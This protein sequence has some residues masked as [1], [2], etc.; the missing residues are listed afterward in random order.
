MDLL[1]LLRF[2]H[3]V[4]GAAWWGTVFFIVFILTSSLE[5]VDVKQRNKLAAVIYPRIYN[6]TTVVSSATIV[7]GGASALLLSGG[8]LEVFFTPRGA[9]LASGSITGLIVYVA[10]LTVERRERSVL[11]VLAEF[12]DPEKQGSFL[13]DMRLI[14][15]IGFILLTYTMLSMIYFTIGA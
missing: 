2:L 4:F 9:L 12:E 15:R 14:P 6:V 7:L 1:P 5:K 11:R 10:H 13:R 8:R 3:A